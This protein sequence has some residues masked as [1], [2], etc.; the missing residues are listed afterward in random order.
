MQG[1]SHHSK[2]QVS[3][4]QYPGSLKVTEHDQHMVDIQSIFN[5]SKKVRKQNQKLEKLGIR[6]LRGIDRKLRGLTNIVTTELHE[7]TKIHQN[8]IDDRQARMAAQ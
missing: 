4:Q 3:D 7:T 5:S 6:Q 2:Q 1:V 8:F